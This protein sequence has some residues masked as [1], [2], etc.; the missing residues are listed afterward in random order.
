[1]KISTFK[2]KK[3]FIV[4]S[5]IVLIMNLFSVNVMA[6]T[7]PGADTKVNLNLTGVSLRDAFRALAEVAEMNIITDNSVQG[8]VTINLQDITFL[9]AVELLAKTNGLSY[10]IVGNTVLVAPPSRLKAGF[11]EKVTRVFKLKNSEPAEVKESLNLLVKD[12]AIRV[13]DRTKSLVVTAYKSQLPQIKKVIN[14]LDQSKKQIVLQARIE[15]ISRNELEELGISWD[16]GN[17]NLDPKQITD[18]STSNDDFNNIIEVG[19]TELGYKAVMNLLESNG[20]ATLLANPQ[21]A[22]IDG[23]EATIEIGDEVPIVT[24]VTTDKETTDKVEFKNIGINLK[25]TPR[26]TNS[27][28]IV[29]K[30]NPKVSTITGYVTT[31]ENKYP[32]ISTREAKTMIRVQDGKTI[33]IGGLIKDEEIENL[34]KVPLLGDIPIFG[35][36][37]Q[38]KK[39]D[40][41][42]RELVIFIT[43]KIISDGEEAIVERESLVKSKENTQNKSDAEFTPYKVHKDKSRNKDILEDVKIVPFEYKV[44]GTDTFWSISKQFKISF[45]AIMEHNGIKYMRPLS[46]GE[47]LTIP[48]PANN[49]Y[50]VKEGDTV[51]DIAEEYNIFTQPIRQINSIKSLDGKAG[52]KLVL[53]VEVKEEDRYDFNE[54]NKVDEVKESKDTEIES[55]DKNKKNKDEESNNEEVKKQDEAENSTI[56]DSSS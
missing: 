11:S 47:V 34:T 16:F 15:E 4:I 53:P 29:V 39:V 45:A 7:L 38:N 36:L 37:F 12:S 30:V 32:Q 26:V 6:E 20:N 49:Y 44:K 55:K 51:K 25:I 46:A 3:K 28:E 13:D 14:K 22:T 21:I 42:K 1:V 54:E 5:L 24:T 27:N 43:P 52:M 19:S 9:E 31:T 23:E 10:R 8:N 40:L 33:A 35:K 41:A 2:R 50:K 17:L 56:T 18:K 48:V